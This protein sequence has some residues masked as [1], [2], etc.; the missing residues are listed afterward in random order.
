[1]LQNVPLDPERIAVLAEAYRF[2]LKK[3]S[4]VERDDPMTQ[5]IAKKIIEVSRTGVMHPKDISVLALRE[6]KLD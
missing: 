3:L 4:L 1:M 5:M 2:T 6:L